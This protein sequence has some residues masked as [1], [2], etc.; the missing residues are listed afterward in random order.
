MLVLCTAACKCMCECKNGS[1]LTNVCF[2]HDHQSHAVVIK[3]TPMFHILILDTCS[4]FIISRLQCQQ[5]CSTLQ[6]EKTR[7]LLRS[8]RNI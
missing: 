1:F 8:D 3:I 5:S 6:K 2:F 7:S 4:E